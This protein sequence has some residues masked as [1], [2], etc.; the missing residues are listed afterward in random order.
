MARRP[1]KKKTQ[2]SPA[3]KKTK[4]E[5]SRDEPQQPFTSQAES[6]HEALKLLQNLY[7]ARS[8][9]KREGYGDPHEA[10]RLIRGFIQRVRATSLEIALA[11]ILRVLRL[12]DD[13]F[14]LALCAI[15]AHYGV[16]T[17]HDIRTCAAIAAGFDPQRLQRLYRPII[18]GG[19]PVV[20]IAR[21]GR[22]RAS[23]GL[24]QMASKSFAIDD[25]EAEELK[26]EVRK[27]PVI[28]DRE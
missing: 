9:F 8:P 19:L 27:L 25:D 28:E 24:I 11:S 13:E 18:R 22:L 20:T 14:I 2:R 21:D 26:E 7:A 23:P 5:A 15:A 6:W 4:Q 3:P 16:V 12:R 17:W 10:D 1:T